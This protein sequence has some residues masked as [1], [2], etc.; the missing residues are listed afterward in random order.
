VA[1]TQSGDERRRA[2]RIDTDYSVVFSDYRAIGP[3]REGRVTD[4][5]TG[6]F[7]VVTRNPERVGASLQLEIQQPVEKGG[8]TLLFEGRVAH[9]STLDD[10]EYAM[11][12]RLVRRQLGGLAAPKDTATVEAARA[13]VPARSAAASVGGIRAVAL[14]KPIQADASS[15]SAVQSHGEVVTF[16]KVRHRRRPGSWGAFAA[17]L[18]LVIILLLLIAQAVNDHR[19]KQAATHGG[20]VALRTTADDETSPAEPE[21]TAR[22]G[23]P[24]TSEAGAPGDVAGTDP[25]ALRDIDLESEWQAALGVDAEDVPAESI[26]YAD[27]ERGPAH[28]E[29]RL[30]YAEAAAAR[31]ERGLAMAVIRRALRN[32][33]DVPDAWR[34]LALDALARLEARQPLDAGTMPNEPAPFRPAR[35]DAVVNPGIEIHVD[36]SEHVMRVRRNGATVASFPVGLGR[37]GSTPLG[38]FQI[39]N[40]VANPDWYNQ[41]R[42]VPAG[43]LN[44]PLGA[45]WLGLAAGGAALPYGIHPTG[46]AA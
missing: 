6:G 20:G 27:A 24:E 18:A 46:D 38:A 22:I 7:R 32:A 41:G 25:A 10:G 28:F 40:K 39:G 33:G 3:L 13:S 45:Q 1:Q 9:V 4:Q 29:K 35:S 21:D 23:S 42:V 14:S 8:G 5:S 36:A 31:G 26:A 30:R 19:E 15:A 43:S 17:I 44:N 37:D 12:I 16:R 2:K 11:G 34:D